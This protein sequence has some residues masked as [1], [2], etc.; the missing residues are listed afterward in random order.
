MSDRDDMEL[1]IERRHNAYNLDPHLEYEEGVKGP[2]S[3]PDCVC[4]IC[5]VRR[6][7]PI[8][9]MS[10]EAS[11]AYFHKDEEGYA[12]A[13]VMGYGFLLI[14]FFLAMSLLGG[15]YAGYCIFMWVS[16]AHS[17]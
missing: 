6:G 11:A 3:V 9:V 14:L 8:N 7:E 4:R 2:E 15:V 17:S 13:D 16:H 1:E 10:R 5:R 12:N